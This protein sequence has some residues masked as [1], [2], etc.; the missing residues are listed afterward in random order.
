VKLAHYRNTSMNLS[1]ITLPQPRQG[2]MKTLP[3][4]PRVGSTQAKIAT[5]RPQPRV[6]LLVLKRCP[7]LPLVDRTSFKVPT[8]PPQPRTTSREPQRCLTSTHSFFP[9]LPRRL[10]HPLLGQMLRSSTFPRDTASRHMRQLGQ[11]YLFPWLHYPRVSL[12][13]LCQPSQPL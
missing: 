11:H 2:W 10:S 5:C 8:C 4:R 1:S 13:F 3:L 12:R 9:P 7:M 6:T